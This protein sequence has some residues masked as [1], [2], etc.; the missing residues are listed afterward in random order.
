[1][2]SLSQ[3]ETHS[4]WP[5]YLQ[6]S[7]PIKLPIVLIYF[8]HLARFSISLSLFLFFPNL[9]SSPDW[10]LLLKVISLIQILQVFHMSSCQ[11]FAHLVHYHK[12]VTDHRYVIQNCSS[13]ICLPAHPIFWH[14]SCTCAV[15]C[16]SMET[17]FQDFR[18]V[19]VMSWS[20]NRL[21]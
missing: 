17:I 19:Q 4:K 2:C 9:N 7:P 1:M 10:S 8:L 15:L 20:T 11:E 5:E 13:Y 16:L 14:L 6:Q 18:M 21:E 3:R 12:P